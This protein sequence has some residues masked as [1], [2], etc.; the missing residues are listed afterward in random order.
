M[1]L[2]ITYIHISRTSQSDQWPQSC[3]G[4]VVY[5]TCVG[6]DRPINTARATEYTNI[7]IKG[8]FSW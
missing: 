7:F 3:G 2:R 4:V 8:L 1:G 5:A 6:T